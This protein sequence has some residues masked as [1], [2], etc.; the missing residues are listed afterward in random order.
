MISYGIFLCLTFHFSMKSLGS[1]ILLQMALFYSFLG[2]SNVPCGTHGI[3]VPHLYF[4]DVESHH[5][6]YIIKTVM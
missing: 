6:F 3:S 2:L 5:D 4:F 1:S